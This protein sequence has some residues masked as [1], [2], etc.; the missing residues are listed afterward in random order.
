MDHHSIYDVLNHPAMLK[1]YL[2]C[3]EKGIRDLFYAIDY[4]TSKYISGY[5]TEK[6]KGYKDVL[7]TIGIT[8][9][10]DIFLLRQDYIEFLHRTYDKKFF[11]NKMKFFF[12]PCLRPKTFIEIEEED[13][14]PGVELDSP[15][16]MSSEEEEVVYAELKDFNSEEE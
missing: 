8:Y 13:D 14:D 6:T 11:G 1:R 4:D 16:S 7:D 9:T 3:V 10:N 2:S 12:C 15:S 5:H